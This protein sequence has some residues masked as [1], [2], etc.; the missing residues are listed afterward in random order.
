MVG[1]CLTRPL[2]E[3]ND[4]F[5]CLVPPPPGVIGARRPS[6]RERT[7][8][9]R[10][11]LR[12]WLGLALSTILVAG[13]IVASPPTASAAPFT[14]LIFSKTA[15]FRHGSITPGIAAIQQLG[16]ANGF[17]VEAT[18]DA[19]QFTD[20]NLDRFAAVIWLS[21]TG[22]VLNAAQQAAF[23]RYITGGGGYVG[24][25]SASDTEYDWQWYGGLVGAY[26]AS[27]PAEQNVTV[28]V[29]D[30]VHPSTAMLPQRWNR[31]DE[32]YNYRTNPRGNAHVLAT[33]DESTYTGG[34]MGA[35]HPI[36]WCQNY[37]GGRAWYTG[38]GHTD[39]SYTEANFRQHLLG[40]IRT[41]A[42]RS[43]PTVVPPSPAASS[44]W[45]WPRARPRPASR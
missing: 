20:A 41:A 18:E 26:F 6:H 30:Q 1:E 31:F 32:L 24:V 7:P 12:S 35:D 42:A 27:H 28:K 9:V 44:R 29:A 2:S 19:A 15:G 4:A 21:T 45:N 10:R 39:A 43:T 8:T 40:G 22:D 38:L 14:V 34:S 16:A 13:G 11:S 5:T 23:E 25:H 37:S 17:T 3:R 36:S 33:L